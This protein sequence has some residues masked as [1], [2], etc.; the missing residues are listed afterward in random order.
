[1]ESRVLKISMEEVASALKSLKDGKDAGPVWLICEMLRVTGKT[2]T[3]LDEV[4]KSCSDVME[5]ETIPED[6]SRN[7]TLPIYTG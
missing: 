7:L 6:W 5:S 1:M 2:C 4:M 3:G